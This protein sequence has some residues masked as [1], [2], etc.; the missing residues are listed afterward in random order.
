[1]LLATQQQTSGVRSMVGQCNCE[2]DTVQSSHMVLSLDAENGMM[3]KG[4]DENGSRDMKQK[5]VPCPA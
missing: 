1:M 2:E 4:E 3:R 5:A